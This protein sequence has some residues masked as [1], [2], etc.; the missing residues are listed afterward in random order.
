MS[1]GCEG[2]VQNSIKWKRK[3]GSLICMN[4]LNMGPQRTCAKHFFFKYKINPKTRNFLSH[5]R[6]ISIYSS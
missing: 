3:K 2:M 6:L 5:E 4:E 1:V